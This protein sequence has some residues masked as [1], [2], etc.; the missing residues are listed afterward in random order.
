MRTGFFAVAILAFAGA[1]CM[2]KKTEA[3]SV[4]PRSEAEAEAYRASQAKGRANVARPREKGDPAAQTAL[5]AP[6]PIAPA[7][8]SEFNQFPRKTTLKWSPVTGAVAYK[9]EVEYQSPDGQWQP[10]VAV[11][12]VK[13]TEYEFDFIG[14]QPGRWHVWAVDA[15]GQE[16]PKSDWW[17]FRYT[18]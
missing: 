15:N 7:N 3:P 11:K 17:S 8:G 1:G 12:E 13:D 9:V 2:S 6:Q 10:A 14:A 5:V 16:G 18:K 4:Q